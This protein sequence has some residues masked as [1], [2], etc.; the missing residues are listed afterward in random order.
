MTGLGSV[1]LADTGWAVTA[2]DATTLTLTNGAAT[3]IANKGQVTPAETMAP[4][5]GDDDVSTDRATATSIAFAT[6][7]TNDGDANAA[8]VVSVTAAGAAATG[9][10]A[11]FLVDA[12]NL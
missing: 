12:A 5:A 10:G 9:A 8:D 11:F 3:L 7:L 2:A 1:T 4:F 6:L